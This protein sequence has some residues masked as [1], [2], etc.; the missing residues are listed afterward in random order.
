MYRR[1]LIIL[2]LVSSVFAQLAWGEAPGDTSKRDI[3][4]PE[5]SS[6]TIP[7]WNAAALTDED[8]DGVT[9]DIDNCTAIANPNQLDANG[10]GFGN[11]CDADLNNDC[12]VDFADLALLRDRLFARYPLA[13]DL[14]GDEQVDLQDVGLIKSAFYQAPGPSGL[15][16]VCDP[17]T[18]FGDL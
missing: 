7:L 14:N 18:N 6:V 16:G 4:K 10:D 1:N 11:A 9:D 3:S 15:V 17:D 5:L 13:Y 2:A 12:T 8:G